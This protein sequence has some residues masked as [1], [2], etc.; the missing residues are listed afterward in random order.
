MKKVIGLSFLLSFSFVLLAACGSSVETN[1]NTQNG[2][3]I[4]PININGGNLP[5][6]ISNAP[7]IYNSKDS[8]GAN[9][10]I[11]G[12]TPTPGIPDPANVNVKIKP[13][14]TPTPGIPS[15]EELRRQ[16]QRGTN[17]APAGNVATGQA[18]NVTST[19]R[20]VSNANGPRTVRK[21]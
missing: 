1:S 12:A 15:P 6:G 16:L 13:G 18:A 21:P 8:N 19:T 10:V 11:P 3:G 5:P 20:Q 2:A 9:V 7:V 14:A 17:A 4:G